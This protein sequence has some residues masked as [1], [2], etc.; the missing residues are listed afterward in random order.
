MNAASILIKPA[1][2]NCNIDC[3]YC[4]YKCL[5]ENR[6]QYSLGFMS[7]ETLET[8][9]KRAFDYVDGSITFAFQGGEPMLAGLAFFKKAIE[10]QKQYN[11]K[12]IRIE[13]TI[14]TNGL[15]INR[16]WAEFFAENNILLGVSLDGPAEL[17]DAYRRDAKGE[18][19]FDRV[20]AS[21]EILNECHV[22]YNI[23]TVVT[24]ETCAHAKELYTFYRRRRFPFVQLIPCMD[25]QHRDDEKKVNQFAV[26]PEKYGTFLC[27][28]FDK[29]YRDY[30]R[31]YRMEH[32]QK[33]PPLDVRM[34]SN[35]AQ[36]AAGYP[37][38][39]CGMCGHC[40]CYMVVEGDGSIYPCDF[41][42][43]DEW[44]LGTVADDF[45]DLVQS[46]K[47]AEFICLSETLPEACRTCEHLP[48]CR[49]GCRRWRETGAPGHFDVNYLCPAY[50]IFFPHAAQA[51]DRLSKVILNAYG[52]YNPN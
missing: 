4:F 27:E 11:K 29:W 20:M 28:F 33:M 18:P 8:L 17:H 49:G 2:S 24:S 50:K 31:G 34:F 1:S 40:T 52:P 51:I 32:G 22:N 19:T 25:E 46:E 35:L 12:N 10:F 3:R 13:N 37:A 26:D 42:C 23:L 21:I 6:E 38:E 9:V 44:K 47:A 39:E 14:Q 30:E 16:E 7:E 5:S 41:Y 36:M 43:T 15:L 48:L 45:N